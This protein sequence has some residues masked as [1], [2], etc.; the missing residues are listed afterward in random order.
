VTVCG[1][2]AGGAFAKEIVMPVLTKPG[3]A[4]RRRP[5]A[6]RRPFVAGVLLL[7]AL[8]MIGIGSWCWFDPSGF[9]RWAGWP[10]HEHFLHDAGVFQVAIGLMLVAALLWRDVVAVAL[11]GLVFTNAFHAL[12]HFLDRADGGHASDPLF[13]LAFAILGAAALVVHRYRRQS[14]AAP[15]GARN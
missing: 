1:S 7:G 5:T 12:N 4:D 11:S 15:S 14:R 3:T 9:A 2:A 10:N 6:A 8:M 13:L